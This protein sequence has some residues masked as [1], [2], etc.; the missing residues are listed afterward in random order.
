ML[1]NHN[2]EKYSLFLQNFQ[3]EKKKESFLNCF[4]EYQ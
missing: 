1:D 3:K 4:T 2:L